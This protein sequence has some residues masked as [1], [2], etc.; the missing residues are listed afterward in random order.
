M[1]EGDDRLHNFKQE[2]GGHRI[3]RN[4]PTERGDRIHTSTV[5]VAV[6]PSVRSIQRISD[7]DIRIEFFSG[8]G[9]GGQH[10]NKH[11][12]CVRA[13]HIPTGISETRQSRE[14]D[15]NIREAKDAL[16]KKIM[17][18][19][20]RSL[21]TETHNLKSSLMGSGERGDKI[22]TYRFQDDT[23]KDHRNGKTF[24][25]NKIMTGEFWRLW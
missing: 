10:R 24:S 20:T 23:V 12:N 13:I 5:S 22:R 8:T 14:R 18:T 11:Q 15:K 19:D 21:A 2:S 4:P 17:E 3:Q 16:I 6:V 7:N 25:A 9:K 1:I